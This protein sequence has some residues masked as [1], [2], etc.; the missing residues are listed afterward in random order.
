MWNETLTPPA[1]VHRLPTA[2]VHFLGLCGLLVALHQP[3]RANDPALPQLCNVES[4]R[5]EDSPADRSGDSPD[6]FE[7][8]AAVGELGW[9]WRKKLPSHVRWVMRK[10]A[11]TLC[12]QAKSEFGQK[13]ASQ[14]PEGCIFLAPSACTIV[15]PGPISPASIGNAVRDCVP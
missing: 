15:T 10:D 9:S 2:T 7:F 13:L 14:I 3:A 6:C 11:L 12:E 8:G 1:A 4:D 5:S